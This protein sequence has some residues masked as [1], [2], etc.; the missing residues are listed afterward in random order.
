MKFCKDC[1]FHTI[2]DVTFPIRLMARGP[3]E[4]HNVPMCSYH[5]Q[6]HLNIDL[7]DGS[8]CIPTEENENYKC[9]VQRRGVPEW[10]CGKE[11]RFY[12]SINDDASMKFADH[13][14]A[15]QAAYNKWCGGK[16][17]SESEE[18]FIAGYMQSAMGVGN[19]NS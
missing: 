8:I 13:H 14:R 3:S 1:K 5:L 2:R 16:G 15:A 10:F 17:T 6:P 4:E 7:V 18:A 12:Q 11:G 9:S 19:G